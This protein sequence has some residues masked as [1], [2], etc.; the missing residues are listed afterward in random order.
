[1]S[2]QRFSENARQQ[3]VQVEMQ[4]GNHADISPAMFIDRNQSF[5]PY[6]E[7]TARPDHAR[8]DRP[9]KGTCSGAVQRRLHR[10]LNQRNEPVEGRPKADI[11]DLSLQIN[12]AVLECENQGQGVW[13]PV[14]RIARAGHRTRW[15]GNAQRAG[16]R[17][18]SQKPNALRQVAEAL[19]EIE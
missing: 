2:E 7:I 13:M 6:L 16:H 4:L 1:M 5:Y 18:R 3:V 9:C 14:Y 15:K 10:K 19:S 12:Q 8:I 11:L 17:H